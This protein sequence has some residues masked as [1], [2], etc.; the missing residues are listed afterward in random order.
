MMQKAEITT[1]NIQKS[2]ILNIIENDFT[3][4]RT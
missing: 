3:L 2:S 1:K 4:F